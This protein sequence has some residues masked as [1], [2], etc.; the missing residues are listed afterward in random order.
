MAS[1]LAGWSSASASTPEDSD[2][3]VANHIK[4]AHVRTDADGTAIVPWA[5]RE[6]LQYVDVDLLGSDW[7]VDETDLKRIK[8]G[9]DH[10]SRPTRAGPCKA[11]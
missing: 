7:K 1:R 3:I 5:P 10:G 6:K 11:G 8:T 9:I 2:W 4:A